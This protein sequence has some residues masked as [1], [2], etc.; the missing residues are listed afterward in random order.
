MEMENRKISSRSIESS[1]QEVGRGRL[2]SLLSLPSLPRSKVRVVKAELDD[3]TWR[4]FKTIC[5]AKGVLVQ[6]QIADL[7]RRFVEEHASEVF[8]NVTIQNIN[9]QQNI[10]QTNLYYIAYISKLQEYLERYERA[11]SLEERVHIREELYRLIERNKSIPILDPDLAKRVQ[12]AL[13][14]PEP[15]REPASRDEWLVEYTVQED[16]WG[17]K[18]VRRKTAKIT[19]R[20]LVKLKETLDTDPTAL[21]MRSRVNWLRYLKQIPH[22]LA[23]ELLAKLEKEG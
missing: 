10:S 16:L 23:Q 2:R 12:Q 17:R 20:D 9:I 1:D 8:R 7:I 13:K 18:V 22:P 6:R 15:P 5:N 3:E 14:P 4:L 21:S 11:G 19:L